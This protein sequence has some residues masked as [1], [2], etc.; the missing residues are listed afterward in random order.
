MT[1]S[2]ED[3]A[4]TA[5]LGIGDFD[6]DQFEKGRLTP[7]VA[8]LQSAIAAME[9]EAG[10]SPDD[11]WLTSVRMV[12][13]SVEAVAVARWLD[14]NGGGDVQLEE[15]ARRT[16]LSLNAV[17]E[18]LVDLAMAGFVGLGSS[19]RIGALKVEILNK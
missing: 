14:A 5:A 15:V 17:G 7:P 11:D 12:R 1:N 13:L 16:H 10:V 4:L 3:A 9:A 19:I 2:D 6:L 8:A 18:A